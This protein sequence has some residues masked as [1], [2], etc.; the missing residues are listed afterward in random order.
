[1]ESVKNKSNTNEK[2]IVAEIDETKGAL[3]TLDR[4][5]KMSY[6]GTSCSEIASMG[7]LE[8]GMYLLDT[9]AEGSEAPFQVK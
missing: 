3:V 9:D 7:N 8:S 2:L 6:I 1:M 5:D 4:L